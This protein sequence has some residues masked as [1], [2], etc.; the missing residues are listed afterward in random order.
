MINTV[1]I[2]PGRLI[3]SGEGGGE[4]ERGGGGGGGRKRRLGRC[5]IISISHQED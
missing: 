5:M 4:G 3:M 2:S 1:N